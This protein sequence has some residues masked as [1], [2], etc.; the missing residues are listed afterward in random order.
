MIA[1][2]PLPSLSSFAAGE[3]TPLSNCQTIR[4]ALVED[5]PEVETL[6]SDAYLES[7]AGVPGRPLEYAIHHSVKR[8]L[9]WR[10][11]HNVTALVAAFE[12][13]DSH[14]GDMG[15]IFVPKDANENDDESGLSRE[16][17]EAC[18]SGAFCVLDKD[19]AMVGSFN[20]N[21]TCKTQHATRRRLVV[22]ADTSK[23]NWW[24]TGI[25]AGL[26][27]HVLVLEHA[28]C[29]IRS[30]NNQSGNLLE[31]S[32]LLCVDTT[33]P[34]WLPPP[35]GALRGMIRLLQKAYPDRIHA[36]YVGPV[37]PW[38]RAIWARI[39]PLIKPKI[40]NKIVLLAEAPSERLKEWWSS[41]TTTTTTTTV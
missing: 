7:V 19:V 41:N 35:L 22:Y 28:F 3:T 13:I 21:A 31:E 17:I 11:S 5:F 26:Q 37:S 8:A 4:K 38:L 32:L 12:A 23:L 16:L 18:K 30:E 15:K 33:A 9:E 39:R 36:I 29:R 40:R 2:S 20:D 6:Y 24:K 25:T 1:G 10:R 34:P 14:R 27:Y